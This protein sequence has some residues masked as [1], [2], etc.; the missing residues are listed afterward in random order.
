MD[1]NQFSQCKELTHWKRSWYWERLK[2]GGE[3]DDRGW[4]GWMA[5]LNWWTWVLASFR[6]W[7]WTG[8]PGIL[9]SMGSQ[10]VKFD[11]AT[12]L[13]WTEFSQNPSVPFTII[14]SMFWSV[15]PTSVISYAYVLGICNFFD[16]RVNIQSHTPN[17]L[18]SSC[19]T[20]LFII[21]E[22]SSLPSIPC[23]CRDE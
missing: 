23:P 21:L 3:G 10:R 19:G 22:G 8:K 14:C 13:S 12:K 4:D 6:S 1:S 2:A 5:S 16:W 9:Q 20:L 7:W 17:I 18:I 15:Q 11:W